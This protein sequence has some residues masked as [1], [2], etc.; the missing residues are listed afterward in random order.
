VGWQTPN[1]G[2]APEDAAGVCD[3]AAE[4][5]AVENCSSVLGLVELPAEEA[6][7][8]PW[9]A[10]VDGA[11]FGVELPQALTISIMARIT[12]RIAILANGRRI[13]VPLYPRRQGEGSHLG[14]R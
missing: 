13:V 5:S 9:D 4:A 7:N 12:G 10:T 14:R 1:A 6:S 3:A 2:D 8:G 11:G